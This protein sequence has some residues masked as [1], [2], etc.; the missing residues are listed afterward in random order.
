MI[1][2][3]SVSPMRTKMTPILFTAVL[4]APYT[5]PDIQ[6]EFKRL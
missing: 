2:F 6:Q 1:C 5:V 3:M 4:P